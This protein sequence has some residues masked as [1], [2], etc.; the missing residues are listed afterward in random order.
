MT[1]PETEPGPGPAPDPGAVPAAIP[2]ARR[3]PALAQA[4]GVKP[5]PGWG[6]VW[7]QILIGGALGLIP[8]FGLLCLA[9][10]MSWNREP[11]PK[12][13]PPLQIL[14]V[15]EQEPERWRQVPNDR[16]PEVNGW[17]HVPNNHHPW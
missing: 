14:P 6:G 10:G 1:S 11:A 15:P 9:I 13:Q 4:Q 8:C 7:R 3:A 5:G 12:I 2:V 17:Q 16:R